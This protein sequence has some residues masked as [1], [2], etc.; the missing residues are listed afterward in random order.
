M[1][2]TKTSSAVEISESPKSKPNRPGYL[3]MITTAIKE[4]NGPKRKG[5][6]K[7]SIAKYIISNNDIDSTKSTQYINAAL[8]A[9][10]KSGQLYQIK[11]RGANGSFRLSEENEEPEQK[12]V[13]KLPNQQKIKKQTTKV[14]TKVTKAKTK[15]APVKREKK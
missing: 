3:E 5:S 2:R 13:K 15:S 8:R 7:Q 12:N 1:K 14:T 6:S 11:G 4:L 10:V 9:G